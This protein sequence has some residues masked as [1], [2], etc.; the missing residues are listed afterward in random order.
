MLALVAVNLC[1][2]SRF[3][4]E[5]RVCVSLVENTMALFC[6]IP[7][8]KKGMQGALWDSKRQPSMHHAY[9]DTI[10]LD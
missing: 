2:N 4:N 1:S 5:Q 10:D 7:D 9:F 3:C 6:L 8:W